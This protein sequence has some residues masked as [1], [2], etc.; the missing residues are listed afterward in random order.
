VTPWKTWYD[1]KLCME[2]H[3]VKDLDR[4]GSVEIKGPGRG[5]LVSRD[6]MGLIVVR[7]AMEAREKEPV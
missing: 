6:D 2:E 4:I 3:G 7:D 1:L 5:L